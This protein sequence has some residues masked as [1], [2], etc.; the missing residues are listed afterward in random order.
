[1]R[2]TDRVES[3]YSISVDEHHEYFAEGVLVKN[4]DACLYAWR[5]GRNYTEKPRDPPPPSPG[6]N[7]YMQQYWDRSAMRLREED[8]EDYHTLISYEVDGF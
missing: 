1:M 2:K 6:S 3:V 7:E 8:E 4:S 5:F